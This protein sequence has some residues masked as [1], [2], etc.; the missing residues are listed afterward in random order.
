MPYSEIHNYISFVVALSRVKSLAGLS[1]SSALLPT[2]VRAHPLVI[3]FYQGIERA[4]NNL[5]DES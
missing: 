5:V 1:L 2:Q 3:D 4:S